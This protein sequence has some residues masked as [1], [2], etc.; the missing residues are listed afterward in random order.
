MLA[1]HSGARAYGHDGEAALD[2]SWLV[3]GGRVY[4]ISGICPLKEY[5]RFQTAFIDVPL[6]LRGLTPVERDGFNEEVL[7]VVRAREGESL[8]ELIERAGGTWD[9]ETTAIANAL[10]TGAVLPEGRRVKLP[11]TRP[12]RV[13]AAS[14][15][16][17]SGEPAAAEPS[18]VEASDSGG[19]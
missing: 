15:L 19:S 7:H 5:E 13:P 4:Q 16:S 8:A 1:G 12:Y 17:I 6:S 9:E 11:V 3:R 2:V 10:S 18:G 14:E